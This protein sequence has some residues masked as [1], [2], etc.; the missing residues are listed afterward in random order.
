MHWRNSNFQYAYF[1]FGACHTAIEAHRKCLEA[2]EDREVAL[3][4]A[5]KA[6]PIQSGDASGRQ[7]RANIEQARSEIKFLN[8]CR[9]KLEEHIGRVPTMDDYQ[10]NQREE[11]RLELEF[12]AEN[13]L[14][15]A[16]TVP[17]DQFATM[18]LHPDFPRILQKI[19]QVRTMIQS[20]KA[21]EFTSPSWRNNLLLLG[22]DTESK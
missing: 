8:Q 22:G 1:I 6:P 13:F 7:A 3:C 10:S 9:A 17:T 19:N 11:W 2:I 12:R 20:G 15:T 16:G 18:R 21:P 4:E 14:L 5:S